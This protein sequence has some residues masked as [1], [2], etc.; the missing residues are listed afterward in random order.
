[1]SNYTYMPITQVFK[2]EENAAAFAERLK[3]RGYKVNRRR[4]TTR[5]QTVFKV[6]YVQ[7]EEN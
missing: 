6:T 2:I 7:Q 4:V 5:H 3:A 1:M